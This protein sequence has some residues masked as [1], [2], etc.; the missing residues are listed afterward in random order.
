MCC[1]CRPQPEA[2]RSRHS[3]LLPAVWICI[4]HCHTNGAPTLAAL[5][6]TL[7][8]GRCLLPCC[9]LQVA[10]ARYW[11]NSEAPRRQDLNAGT[12]WVTAA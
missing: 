11:W 8:L 12:A 3:Q 10:T 6:C 2:M 5:I 4:R 9:A 1:M 7:V